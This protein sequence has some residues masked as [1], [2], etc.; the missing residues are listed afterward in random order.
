MSD[1]LILENRQ[2]LI[3]LS[4]ELEIQELYHGISEVDQ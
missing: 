1:E 3:C 2:F 4:Y